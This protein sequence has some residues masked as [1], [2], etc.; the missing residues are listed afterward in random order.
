MTGEG[1]GNDGPPDTR[2]YFCIPYWTKPLTPGGPWDTGQQRP[3][4][5][6]VVFYLCES[7]QASA[8]TPGQPLHV[9]VA[10]RNSGGGNSASIAT[11]VVYWADPTAGFAKLNFFGATTVA[12]MPDLL[13]PTTATTPTMTATIPA[14]APQHICLLAIVSH[15]QDKAGTGY[16]PNGDRH[17]AQRNLVAVAAAQGAPVIVPFKLANPFPDEAE[18]TLRIAPADRQRAAIVARTLG[19]EDADARPTLRLLDEKGSEIGEAGEQ[20][21]QHFPLKGRAQLGLQVMVEVAE[22][23]RSGTVGTV[24]A[25]VLDRKQEGRVVGALGISLLAP[26]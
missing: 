11:V 23:I 14:D 12:V 3:L 6:S 20:V 1:Q 25:L 16:D 19:L 17:W 26:K 15:P 9:T 24:E 21:V 8:Y 5:G 7:I 2:P 18:L 22:D 10:V 13:T 4:P